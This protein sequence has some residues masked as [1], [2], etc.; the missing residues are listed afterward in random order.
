[1]FE[2]Q[3][4][5]A[6]STDIEQI[7]PALDTRYNSGRLFD[8]LAS[9]ERAAVMAAYDDHADY[10]QGR[11]NSGTATEGL[12]LGALS[13]RLLTSRYM[14]APIAMNWAQNIATQLGDAPEGTKAVFFMRDGNLAYTFTQF[15]I[16]H[17]YAPRISADN[18]VPLYINRNT[19]EDDERVAKYIA[20]SLSGMADSRDV[21][22]TLPPEVIAVD[23]G[24]NGTMTTRFRHYLPY[25][26]PVHA[27]YL[28]LGTYSIPGA[29]SAHA[30]LPT[31]GFHLSVIESTFDPVVF[32]GRYP[33]P[34]KVTDY[35]DE[36]EPV[37]E[38]NTDDLRT[39]IMKASVAGIDLYLRDVA[40]GRAM[41]ADV[42]VSSTEIIEHARAAYPTMS[43][44]EALQRMIRQAA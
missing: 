34:T 30:Y 2:D 11:I 6:I 37:I 35:T 17:G 43:S 12:I 5:G 14:L 41:I 38:P 26:T 3:N 15:L 22:P 31:D 40:A 8:A 42:S 16:D 32:E 24:N 28:M 25:S 18:L 4:I 20:R 7:V 13:E 9:D 21:E 10:W 36:G 23:S 39:S 1:M 27:N 19:L 29:A 33:F 44:L